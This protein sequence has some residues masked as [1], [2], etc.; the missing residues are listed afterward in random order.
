M[1]S[2]FWFRFIGTFICIFQLAPAALFHEPINWFWLVIG[3]ALLYAGIV[4]VSS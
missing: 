4:K 1:D 2:G 3:A